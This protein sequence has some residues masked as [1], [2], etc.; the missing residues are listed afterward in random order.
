MKH[1]SGYRKRPAQSHQDSF[2]QAKTQNRILTN[3]QMNQL[4]TIG[5]ILPKLTMELLMEVPTPTIVNWLQT[6]K[7][8]AL[9][10]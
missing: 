4:K 8:P 5:T 2:A 9:D 3:R 6:T 7:H 1:Q 10:L